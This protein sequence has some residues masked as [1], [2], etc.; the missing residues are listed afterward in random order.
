MNPLL[1]SLYAFLIAVPPAMA[2]AQQAL[3]DLSKVERIK[4]SGDASM[5]SLTTDANQPYAASLKTFKKGWSSGWVSGWFFDDCAQSSQLSLDGTTL[6]VKVVSSSWY[7]ISECVVDATINIPSGATV[8]SDLSA[9]MLHMIGAFNQIDADGSAL[10][11]SLDGYVK[12]ANLS[13]NAM[14]ARIR[15]S[16]LN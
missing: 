5:V 1:L 10:D 2:E 13:G 6:V 12:T 3:L 14:R 11:F 9:S 8:S 16:H 15:F 7:S 4:I